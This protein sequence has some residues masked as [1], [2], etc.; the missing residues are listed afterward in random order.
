[1]QVS[2]IVFISTE[3]EKSK[4]SVISSKRLPLVLLLGYWEVYYVAGFR[5]LKE[6]AC[7]KEGNAVAAKLE[8]S[9][10]ETYWFTGSG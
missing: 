2:S 7:D 10:G 3:N 9:S 6:C 5:T 4:T 8:E 1:M